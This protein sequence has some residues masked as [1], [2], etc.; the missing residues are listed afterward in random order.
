[1][2][3]Y[4]FDKRDIRFVLNDQIE[5]DSI[6]GLKPYEDFTAED[7]DMI[8]GEAGKL[9]VDLIAPLNKLGDEQGC[10]LEDGQ[11]YVP[12]EFKKA[13][14]RF[15]AD[16]WTVPHGK[17]E[18]G[19]QGLPL[20]VAVGLS[21]LFI[22]ACSS[23]MF[24]PGLTGAAAHV[25]E[26]FGTPAQIERYVAKMYSGDWVGTMC[27]T[28]PQAGT[29]VGDA[30]TSAK[31][32]EGED[33]FHIEGN[34]LFISAGDGDFPE[35]VIHLVLARI[36]GDPPGTKGLSLFIVP[37]Y[38]INDDGSVGGS[39]DVVVTAIEHKMGI[40]ASPTCALAFGS[41]GPC[42]GY[43]LG[44][45]R[46]GIVAMFQMMNE[47]RIVTGV[48]GAA[49]A[50]ASYQSALA[51]A[52]ERIQS[53]KATDRSPNA[54]SVPIIEHPDVRR[55]LMIMK[56]VSEGIRALLINTA[57]YYD[58]A[59]HHP[60][61]A[62]RTKYSDLTE[63]LTPVCKSYATDMGFLVTE[64]GIQVYGGYGYIR[65]YPM[66]QYLR[67]VKIASLYEGT[68]GI[69]ALDLLG[70]KM[71]M[72]NGGLL[73]TWLQVINDFV[74][75]NK[76][77]ERL[78]SVVASLDKAKNVLCEAAFGLGGIGKADPE[79]F[80]LQATP[81]LLAFGHV[82]VGRLLVEQAVLA[83]AKL[84]ELY[85]AKGAS[86]DEAKAELINGDDEARFFD[87]KIKG[88]EFFSHEF[89]SQVHSLAR[90]IKKPSRAALDVVF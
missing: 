82:E 40:N 54:K 39:N 45:R 58:L 77:H 15:F 14:K 65:E 11:V 79:L 44:E 1:L 42:Q 13:Y 80:L 31:E 86:D 3:H 53:P 50:N 63:L 49:L 25:I 29:S 20:S 89:L 10:R 66:E 12:E 23:F 70:R 32:V 27:L 43:L 38:L 48:Q 87:G 9:A 21:E 52:R 36:P 6:L 17:P 60:D 84:Q 22:G 41:D 8:L 72:K 67:D 75:A 26:E 69:Q 83:D 76:D 57:R 16:G 46:K 34:K 28:E 4:K 19:G 33:Y 55:N 37:K 24:F 64:R 81:F 61:E 68:N 71:R 47:A 35:N 7:V 30:L 59:D 85:E 18:F 74:A 5:L 88:A 51:Y 56:T 2:S 78:G 90:Q 62:A 73:L